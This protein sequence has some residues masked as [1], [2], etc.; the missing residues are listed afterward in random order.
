MVARLFFRQNHTL[1]SDQ[2]RQQVAAPA[3]QTLDQR[4]RKR[5]RALRIATENQGAR[6]A[7]WARSGA[8]LAIALVF[9]AIAEWNAALLY[10]LSALLLFFVTGLLSYYLAMK[11]RRPTWLSM[12]LATVDIALLTILIV[13]PNPFATVSPPPAMALREAGFKYLL[14]IVCLGALSLSPRLAIWLGVTAAIS[15]ALGVVWVVRQ[16][17]TVIAYGPPSNYSYADQMALFFN[18]N[19]VDLVEQV[20]RILVI[21][22]IASIVATVVWRARQLADDYT[23]AE[24]ARYNLSRHF[25]PNVVDELA[26]NDEPFGPIRRQ[27]IAVIFADIIGFTAYTEDH[28]AE[29]VFELLREFHSRMEAVVFEHKGTVDNYIGDCIMATFG[30]PSSAPDDAARAL[31][32]TRAMVAALDRWNVERKA[33]GQPPVDIRIGCQFGPVVLGAIG[34]ERNLSFAAVGDTCNVASRLQNLCRELD[35]DI[36]VGAAVIEAAI[37]AGDHE[38]S[39]GFTN[40]GPVALRGR[41]E[42]V[43]VWYIRN[44]H[45]QEA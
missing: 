39:A 14:I 13:A 1:P 31:R 4:R 26:S 45:K 3:E 36:C 22:I 41:E 34:S 18:P 16:P 29:Q 20:T 38:G 24:R 21:L 27:E 8:L 11:G 6:L 17:G 5:L 32:A 33:A 43:D 7:F 2:L 25:S 9:A 37:V 44:A 35:A 15:W 28:P 19:F 23:K 10:T 42:L 40:H 30:V 12:V